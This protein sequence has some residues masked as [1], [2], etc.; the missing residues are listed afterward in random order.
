M[1][2]SRN[3]IVHVQYL[4]LADS[5]NIQTKQENHQ[6][7]P[8]FDGN[9][10][11]FF[12]RLQSAYNLN[13]VK[14]ITF[15]FMDCEFSNF[16]GFYNF[17]L[18]CREFCEKHQIF[19]LFLDSRL[20]Q[21]VSLI[22]QTK[23]MVKEGE[24][25][26]I[27]LLDFPCPPTALSF[28]RKKKNY[29]FVKKFFSKFPPFTQQWQEDMFQ[30]LNPK[31]I[32]FLKFP[33]K[34]HGLSDLEKAQKFFKSYNPMVFDFKVGLAHTMDTIVNKV[35]HLMDKKDDPYDVEVPCCGEF[36]IRYN[37]KTL[38]EAGETE[39]APFEKSVIV[40]TVPKK[41]VSKVKVTLKLD[42]NSFY[43]F[44]VEPFNGKN[45]GETK[46]NV[47]ATS[48]V[49]KKIVP[50]K[51]QMIFDKQN[52]SVS[53][54]AN[55][56][57]Y[58]INDLDEV[59]KTPIYIAF[60]EEKPIIGKSAMEVYKEKSKFVV[61]DLIKLCSVSTEDICNPK[62]GFKLSKEGEKGDSLCLT[63]ETLEGE[64]YT[65]VEFL[66]ALVLKNGKDR[67]KKETGKKFEEVEIKFDGF[68]PNEILKKNFIEA[69]K[70]LKINIVFV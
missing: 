62:W 66:L 37:G 18:K 30:G 27:F 49:D 51:A 46:E 28:I 54:F 47:A 55:G 60:T 35:L 11:N 9:I 45:E 38:I 16:V 17:R 7:F 42:I 19:Y 1:A 4:K 52:F 59:V 69:A 8:F 70:L 26:M 36:E 23:T 41:S 20:F 53:Y 48:S 40:N 31:K 3:L 56:K 32:I 64:K 15:T 21:C 43:D 5:Y 50:E 13:H 39:I 24:K 33:T 29:R 25:V 22:S 14:A 63:F 65:T 61:F 10:T 2:S 58:N 68:S 57:E 44:K 34:C 67:V 12:A 6:E